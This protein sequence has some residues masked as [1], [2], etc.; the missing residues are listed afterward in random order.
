MSVGDGKFAPRF[1]KN[2]A[3]ALQ[4]RLPGLYYEKHRSKLPNRSGMHCL[5]KASCALFPKP[6]LT[7]KYS[8]KLKLE[9]SNLESLMIGFDLA[10]GGDWVTLGVTFLSVAACKEKDNYMEG[11]SQQQ[12]HPAIQPFAAS[13][14]CWRGRCRELGPVKSLLLA[15]GRSMKKKAGWDGTISFM[16]KPP[17]KCR[18]PQ[19]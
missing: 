2:I 19:K 14:L 5:Q 9:S 3:Q 12:C 13:A 4:I 8:L 6:R 18:V 11:V 16:V 7:D 10:N 1:D 17:P 15:C